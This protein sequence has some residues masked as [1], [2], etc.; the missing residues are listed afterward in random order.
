MSVAKVCIQQWGVVL[1]VLNI[2]VLLPQCLLVKYSHTRMGVMP[3]DYKCHLL[4]PCE[5][6]LVEVVL[7]L[8]ISYI[9]AQ[10]LK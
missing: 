8:F 6:V 2:C 7:D 10:L 9:D 4:L 1:M 3:H 5:D